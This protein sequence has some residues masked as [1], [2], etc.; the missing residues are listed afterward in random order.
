MKVGGTFE[1]RFGDHVIWCAQ[2]SFR[3]YSKHIEHLCTKRTLKR[4]SYIKN[5]QLTKEQLKQEIIKA[6]T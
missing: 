4:P 2:I 6:F 1:R 3:D 5:Y